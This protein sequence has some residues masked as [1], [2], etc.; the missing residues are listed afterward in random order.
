M[1]IRRIASLTALLAVIALACSSV[2]SYLAPRGPGS[3]NWEAMG[4]GKH[5]WFALHTNLGLLFLIACI[6]HVALNW[7]PIVA[8]LKNKPGHF[9]LFTIHFNIAL[10]LTLWVIV[11]SVFD[12][13]PFRG[14]Q[15][16]KESLGNRGRHH[17]TAT[18]KDQTELP[19]KPPF[20]YS[21]RS[22]ADLAEDYAISEKRVLDK[23]KELGIKAEADW[24]IK[25]IAKQNDMASESVYEVLTGL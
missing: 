17:A 14:I 4:L 19:E 18:V 13:P 20:F 21:R 15:Q 8:Y 1:F 3:S 16:Y 23:F 6:V 5:E 22:V 7:K 2:A 9:R 12:W 25:E 11:S 24:P 10:L